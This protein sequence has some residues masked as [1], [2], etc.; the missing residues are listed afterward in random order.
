MTGQQ[1]R[2]HESGDLHRGSSSCNRK[3]IEQLGGGKLSGWGSA[4]SPQLPWNN[5]SVNAY[6][7]ID[8][9]LAAKIRTSTSQSA[10]G[11]RKASKS[12]QG[13][14]C[15]AFFFFFPRLTAAIEES[16]TC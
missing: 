15:Y 7:E 13:G 14:W 4:L 11:R 6:H 16:L 3:K 8:N 5:H 10:L 12:F 1:E 2:K 9:T